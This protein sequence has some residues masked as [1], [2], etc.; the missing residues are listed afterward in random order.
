MKANGATVKYRLFGSIEKIRKF[1]T[2][3]EAKGFFYGYCTKQRPG[4]ITR[5]ELI[6]H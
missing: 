6:I 2:V 3:K 4:M 5:A 1:E